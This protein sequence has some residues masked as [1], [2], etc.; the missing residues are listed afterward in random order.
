[1]TQMGAGFSRNTNPTIAARKRFP[2]G[3]LNLM[4]RRVL[5]PL[6]VNVVLLGQ[7]T[8]KG[9]ERIVAIGDVHGG[10]TAFVDI[11][12][13]AQI[14]DDKNGWTGGRTH[15]VQVGDVLD[16]GADSRKAMELLM[17]LERQANRAG[18]RVH[19]LIGNHE[20]MNLYGDLRYVSPGEFAA[21]RGNES[22]AQVEA[23]W[24]QETRKMRP[25]PDAAFRA[26]WM[27]EH[28]PG[29]VEHR[30]QFGPQGRYGKWIR[31]HKAII[32]INDTL[33]LHGGI[34]PKYVTKS[35]REINDGIEAEL[36]D[37]SKLAQDGFVLDEQGPLW[38]RGIAQENPA[39]NGHVQQVLQRF[40]V[41]RVVIGHTPTG[42]KILSLYGGAV[43]AIDVGLSE[44]YGAHRVCL[45]I[46]GDLAMSLGQDHKT[47]LP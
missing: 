3:I 19:S 15:L 42:G 45:V 8:W 47:P 14:I 33:F 29:W 34:S 31:G 20:A 9:V 1:M 46:E 4:T 5:F 18:G 13:L 6:L 2:S 24:E 35:M 16:R 12:R 40:G 17:S 23:L 21:F 28:P 44:V 38:Y 43:A 41:R 22:A 37:F 26:K 39:L 10:Y 30:A 25:K 7:D 36:Q 32:R 11:L 27:S